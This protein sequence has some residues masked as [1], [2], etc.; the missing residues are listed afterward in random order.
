MVEQIF[1]L[2]YF[3]EK[4]KAD[5]YFAKNVLGF[6]DLVEKILL[7]NHKMVLYLVHHYTYSSHKMVLY[8]DNHYMLA[9]PH[10]IIISFCLLSAVPYPL[11]SFVACYYVMLNSLNNNE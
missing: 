2:L 6:Y 11:A 1:K 9:I 10:L 3:K 4:G 7:S 8:S 5:L